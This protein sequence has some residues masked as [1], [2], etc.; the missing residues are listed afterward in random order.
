MYTVSH[1]QD[2]DSV[3]SNCI[4][5]LLGWKICCNSDLSLTL[6]PQVHMSYIYP[7]DYTRLTHMES[8]NSCFYPESPYYMRM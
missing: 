2:L 8:E 5:H 6:F 3:K 1:I 4:S 7:N